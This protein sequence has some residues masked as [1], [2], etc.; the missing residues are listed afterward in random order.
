MKRS[1]YTKHFLILEYHQREMSESTF[2]EF[3]RRKTRERTRM[4]TAQDEGAVISS[5]SPLSNMCRSKNNFEVP[6]LWIGGLTA[7]ELKK[8][9]YMRFMRLS[10]ILKRK[11]VFSRKYTRNGKPP[12]HKEGSDDHDHAKKT[13]ICTSRTPSETLQS[14]HQQPATSS[15][16]TRQEQVPG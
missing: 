14:A 1:A 11:D 3:R 10:R 4:D 16:P 7:G 8:N 9:T 2:E 12:G 13:H 5:R 15:I 6:E